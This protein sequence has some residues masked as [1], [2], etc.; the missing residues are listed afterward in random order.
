LLELIRRVRPQV[1]REGFY[2]VVEK[3][4][5]PG[6][7]MPR[8][9]GID[10]TTGYERLNQISRV[11]LD[12]AGVP[13]LDD[14][15]RNFTGERAE[16][17]D[18]L[19]DAKRR[20][21]ETMLASEFT[22]LVRALARI[23]AGHLSTRD[24]T[25][26]RLRAA[27]QAY[28]FEFPV[29][30]TYI[31]TS[32][33]SQTDRQKIGD[34]IA[35]AKADWRGPDPEIFEFLRAAITT[36]LAHNSGYS[37][38]R[39]RDFAF[40]LQQFTGPLMAKSL[41]DTA[42]YRYPRLLALNEVGGEPAAVNSSLEHFHSEQM[43]LAQEMPHGLIAT[44]THDTK[45][46]EDARMRILSLAE[47]PQDWR[48]A[49][50]EWRRLNSSLTRSGLAGSC[51]SANHEYMMYQTLIGVWPFAVPDE[52]FTR[53]VQAYALKAAR[54]G[55]RETSWT[56]PNPD[57]EA[58]L[59]EF[60]EAILDQNRSRQFIDSITAFARRTALLGASNSLS[61]LTLK[62][63]LPGVPDFF[64]GS[65]LWDLSL[66]DPDN[67]RPVD[68]SW[69]RQL[70][71]EDIPCAELT[72]D[73]PDGRVKFALMKKLLRLRNDLPG[74]FRDGDYSPLRFEGNHSGHVI[75]FARSHRRQR[76]IVVAGRHFAPLT[77]SGRE[78]P[79]RWDIAFTDQNI[80]GYRDALRSHSRQDSLATMLGDLPVCV[81]VRD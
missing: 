69:R 53:R 30:R 35:R 27:L 42:F 57:Y 74:V 65:E 79:H 16:F 55:K 62:L 56:N 54:E 23:A 8:F 31:T 11:L 73:W 37:G 76:L 3:I 2:I 80:S 75:G 67:R 68:F 22:V 39:V 40:K 48:K 38:H 81:L 29:Y 17:D 47:M 59:H 28:L 60:V 5:G 43:R 20:V 46:G 66:V 70:I 45:R 21:L 15:W 9:R 77:N 34:A 32:Q 14:I 7:P 72:A 24:Y 12:A 49:V 33:I 13:A 78:W 6:E 52:A 61:Q 63:T 51:P 36:D 1:R 25:I 10:G 18:I 44:E 64:Q 71:G 50:A 4:L 58:G 19:H 26:D 41:E